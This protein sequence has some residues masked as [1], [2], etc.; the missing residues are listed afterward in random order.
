VQFH[1]V[2]QRF[3]VNLDSAR[4]GGMGKVYQAQDLHA[5]G[6]LC[7]L[8]VINSASVGSPL[9]ELA[10][11]REIDSLGKLK[12]QHIV[13]LLGEGRDEKL[14]RYLVME[15]L[16]EDFEARCRVQPY[17]EWAIFWSMIGDPIL[18]ALCYA[19]V[20]NC[21]HRDLKPSNVMFDAS[22]VPKLIDFGISGMVDRIGVGLTL[23]GM[24]SEIYAPPEARPRDALRD[25]YGFAAVAVYAFSGKAFESA[26]AFRASFESLQLP[27]GI[28][29]VLARCLD[30]EQDDRPENVV[31][32][33]EKIERAQMSLEP[34]PRVSATALPTI[35]L[36]F[37]SRVEL[38]LRRLNVP[39]TLPVFAALNQGTYVE[40]NQQS[41]AADRLVLI[42][43]EHTLV[44]DRDQSDPSILFVLNLAE[45]RAT[46][47]TFAQERSLL[48]AYRF[49]DSG[50][51]GR[52]DEFEQAIHRLYAGLRDHEMAN[53]QFDELGIFQV[54]RTI[55]RG[56]AEY[57][58]RRYPS[59]DVTGASAEG[60]RISVR[61]LEPADMNLMGLSY[62]IEDGISKIA[63]GAV[64]S[65]TNEGLIL[66]CMTD[67]D[68]AD[69]R[70]AA[71]LRYNASGTDRA[72][73]NQEVALDRVQ[74]NEAPNPDLA[75]LLSDP[76]NVAPPASVNYAP[77]LPKIDSD[78]QMAV[79]S[80]MGTSS[81]FLVVGPPGTGKTEFITELVL[82]EIARKP[83]VRILLSAQTHMAVDNALARI[84]SMQTHLTCIR[85]GKDNDRIAQQSQTLLLENVARR[86]RKKVIDR[87]ESAL[88]SYGEERGVDIERLRARRAARGVI[89]T[90]TLLETSIQRNETLK[91][92]ISS[93]REGAAAG[94]PTSPEIDQLELELLNS[95]E[96]VTSN[97]VRMEEADNAL[98]ICGDIGREM[99]DKLA[100]G[101]PP[102]EV[103]GLDTVLE[104]VVQWMQRLAVAR[105]FYP[106]VLAEAQVVAGTCLGFLGSPGTADMTFDLAIIEEASRALPTEVLV[107]ASRA[108]RIVLVGDNKQLPPFMESELLGDEWLQANGLTR[109]EVEETLFARLEA[110]L[111][112]LAVARLETQYRMHPDIGN[113]VGSLFYPGV[114]KSADSAGEGAVTLKYLG[115]ERNV[116]FVSTSREPD[117]GE[118]SRGTGFINLAEVR[119][120]RILLADILKRARKKRREKLSVVL[121]TPYV[122]NR[123][124][125]ERAVMGMQKDHPNAAVS[126]HTVHTFQGQQADIAVYCCARSNA[127]G[128]LG[129]TRDPRLVNV[130]LSRGRGGLIVVGDAHFL[131][132]DK[133]SL[134]YRDLIAYIKS[135]PESC[136]QK[137][138]KNVR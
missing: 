130:A 136:A 10:L 62:F 24:K 1:L 113:M 67:F 104:I 138:A 65:I 121:L 93:L 83:D 112:A 31:D 39:S 11:Q 92:R 91:A 74:N 126:V 86:W 108:R 122:A 43:S 56:R 109:G 4:S 45:T 17:T 70:R 15:W 37:H 82:Q 35:R 51:V 117:R 119:V 87:C 7:A 42:S 60:A 22:N 26:D 99:M 44:V 123:E 101:S 64:E 58:G 48:A 118:E 89:E 16:A 125:L 46:S 103:A 49:R 77:I 76:T 69:L 33:R 124:A 96:D 23:E 8:K 85:L 50:Y 81:L 128:D 95:R 131:S 52:I 105:D 97:R 6:G 90:R 47:W 94:T 88:A 40:R 71:R 129:F 21:I 18:G 54:W 34:P 63:V 116:L 28:K 73:R 27:A 12:H 57:Y 25:V 66:Y 135:H 84:H 100:T 14:G 3:A 13:P 75:S 127:D 106:A 72:I 111:P 80:A 133:S 78:K 20:R 61:L 38:Q 102:T 59:L 5:A 41:P 98:G 134:A 107:P 9:H 132:R 55:L 2:D 29:D 19:F 114:L 36:R 110:H 30:T 53:E 68:A 137:E 120:A 79:R 115:Y 32:L